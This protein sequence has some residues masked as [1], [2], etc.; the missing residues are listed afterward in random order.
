MRTLP[1]IAPLELLNC[2]ATNKYVE[3]GST[4]TPVSDVPPFDNSF[5]DTGPPHGPLVPVPLGLKPTASVPP[6]P[7]VTKTW[8]FAGEIASC[9]AGAA[10]VVVIENGT[11]EVGR[12]V[13]GSSW[14]AS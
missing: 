7:R 10:N 11:V 6:V 12:P 4:A 5:I 9:G 2:S 13:V 14:S 3:V 1:A 8:V